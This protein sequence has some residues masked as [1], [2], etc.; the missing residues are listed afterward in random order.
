MKNCD[1]SVMGEQTIFSGQ[2]NREVATQVFALRNIWYS[3]LINVP[4]TF[5]KY[6]NT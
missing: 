2:S 5:F 1:E 4:K 6:V 3:K